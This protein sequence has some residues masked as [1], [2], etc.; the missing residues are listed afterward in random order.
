METQ[1]LDDLEIDD[2]EPQEEEDRGPAIATLTSSTDDDHFSLW[3]G[4]NI[5]G[6]AEDNRH[7]RLSH[8]SVSQKHALLKISENNHRRSCE[9]SDLVS[10]CG[11]F[12]EGTKV[13]SGS[14]V[15]VKHGNKIRFGSKELM[16]SWLNEEDIVEVKVVLK[17]PV[18]RSP[19]E[20][21]NDDD[22]ETSHAGHG[23]GNNAP[24]QAFD[25]SICDDGDDDDDESP[26]GGGGAGA[27]SRSSHSSSPV[28]M[29]GSSSSSSSS[30]SS[31]PTDRGLPSGGAYGEE[32]Q[33]CCDINLSILQISH[34][35]S[36]N[37]IVS[38][39]TPTLSSRYPH[40]YL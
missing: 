30:S 32:T 22:A 23:G 36:P 28:R 11:T 13:P 17:L 27:A 9:V 12:L 20:D 26:D 37:F 31:R 38:L 8:G 25:M 7:V 2:D 15:P 4:D 1:F 10:K 33:V 35:I 39:L 5:I 34:L 18:L 6:R 21:N 19:N 40:P 16:F 24:T 29:A 3:V 14:I